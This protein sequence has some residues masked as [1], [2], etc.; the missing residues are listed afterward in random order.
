MLL[1][2]GS[3]FV[4]SV[5]KST[6][7]LHLRTTRI[8]KVD[9]SLSAQTVLVRHQWRQLSTPKLVAGA[10]NTYPKTVRHVINVISSL[11]L[12]FV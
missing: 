9:I 10:T 1:K 6:R 3:S 12:C 5:W 7:E 8:G 2:M 4:N 11:H